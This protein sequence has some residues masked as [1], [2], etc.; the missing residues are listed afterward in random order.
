MRELGPISEFSPA[1]PLA[2]AALAPLRAKAESLGN[3]D[4]TP[5]WAGQN[6][7]GCRPIPA[8]EL[9]RELA[10]HVTTRAC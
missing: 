1:F 3:S 7:T 2:G 4:F 9:T 10:S 5:L 6:T 8:G